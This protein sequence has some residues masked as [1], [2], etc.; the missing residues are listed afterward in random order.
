MVVSKGFNKKQR[1]ARDSG[2]GKVCEGLDIPKRRVS[3]WRNKGWWWGGFVGGARTAEEVGE[4]V[5]DAGGADDGPRLR[6]CT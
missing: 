1:R 4:G 5:E 2:S 3:G 6:A